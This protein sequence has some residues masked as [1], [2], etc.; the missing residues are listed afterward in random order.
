MGCFKLG[1]GCTLKKIAIVI[2]LPLFILLSGCVS[3]DLYERDI[4]ELEDQLAELQQV[5]D[6]LVED[7]Q[8]LEDNM[9][10]SQYSLNIEMTVLLGEIEIHLATI[11]E[12]NKTILIFE[13]NLAEVTTDYNETL[14]DLDL[15]NKYVDELQN[16]LLELT[17]NYD[18][19]LQVYDELPDTGKFIHINGYG[20]ENEEIF[21]IMF[22]YELR[23]YVRY[24]ITYL[25]C[26][27]RNAD[28]NYWQ[29]SFVEINKYTNDIIFLSF[30]EDS[31][32]HYS[33]GSWGDSNPTLSGKTEE[34]FETD[35]IPWLIGKS[36]ID[37]EGISVFTNQDYYG[38][39]N[40]TNIP[41]TDLIDS[42]AGSSV[43]TNNM[44]R[45][46]KSLLEYHEEKYSD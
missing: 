24:Q 16:T 22:Q 28:A 15:L 44:I 34:D 14:G 39:I 45:V 10:S 3:K 37:L 29:V 5:K 4:L 46:M 7:Y 27:S 41:E 2:I 13:A 25:S 11:T 36:L 31:S 9:S 33:P 35:F 42:Y 19:L 17:E 30:D 18:S 23:D 43:T 38:I 21:T 20:N 12:L 26:T 1:G 8:V 40:T 6:D 32:G